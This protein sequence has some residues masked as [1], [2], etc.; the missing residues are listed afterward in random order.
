MLLDREPLGVTPVRPERRYRYRVEAGPEPATPDVPESETLSGATL[1][2]LARGRPL[3]ATAA[4][5]A[6]RLMRRV[7]DHYLGGRP[8][9]SRELFAASIYRPS[10]VKGTNR[11]S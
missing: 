7:L 1:L 8:L 4:R 9:K 11:P 5:E 3:D 10:T 6:R 2:A